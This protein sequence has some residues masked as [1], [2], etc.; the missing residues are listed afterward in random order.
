M[1]VD[2][3]RN[4][5]GLRVVLFV[6]GCEHRC[7]FC[8]NPQTWNIN[9]GT[10]FD[11]SAK[12]IVFEYLNRDY[13]AGI[14][15]SGGDPLYPY[16]VHTMTEFTKEI[17]ATY[18]NKTIWLYTGYEYE[19]VQHREIM[20]YIDV[21]VDGKFVQQLADVNYKWAGSK[22]QRVIDIKESQKQNRVILLKS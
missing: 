12:Q 4:G 8:H 13:I 1:K 7:K 17:K 11:D 14:T 18:P 21:L 20:K 10:P 15:L 6:S 3:L 16:N 2:D 9:S 22:N 5:E 19:V